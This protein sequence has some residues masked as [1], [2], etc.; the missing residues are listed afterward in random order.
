VEHNKLH[1]YRLGEAAD[2]DL[3]EAN[4][5]WL[6]DSSLPRPVRM[7]I[8]AFFASTWKWTYYAP[9]TLRVLMEDAEKRERP[10][11][12]EAPPPRPRTLAS[13][14]SEPALWTRCMLPYAGVQ[15]GL[16][17]LLFLP[18]GP[19]AAS[20]VLI[21]S[22]L[23][24]WFT[25]LHSFLIITTNH[26]G[27]DMYAFDEPVRQG[28]GEFYFRQVVGSTN[29]RTGGDLNDF[30]HGFLNYQIEHH[31]FPDMSMLQYQRLQPQV[32]ALC[33]KYGVPYVQESVFTRLRKTL[34]VML[35]DADML[36]EA[37]PASAAA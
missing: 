10:E 7:A 4:L 24:E 37:P 31:V 18:L 22:L 8:I 28:K 27:E 36:R 26:A 25:N 34:A 14:W 35:G 5:D 17:P 11:T 20:N 23:A 3:V 13:M 9:N 29:F 21:N 30:L 33:E 16:V 1:H 32:R 6:R 12:S 2:P 19:A 15:F